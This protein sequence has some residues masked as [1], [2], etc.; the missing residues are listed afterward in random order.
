MNIN[1]IYQ[2]NSFNFDLR[3]DASIKYLEDLASKLI[4]KDKASFNLSYKD[5]ILTGYSNTL[6]KDILKSETNVHITISP[7]MNRAG[8]KIKKDLPKLRI[9]NHSISNTESIETKNNLIM[10]ETELSQSFSENSIKVLQHLSKHNFGNNKKQKNEYEY[11]TKN[12]IFEEVYNSK[13]SELLK[14]LKILSQKIKEYDD[15]LYKKY[16]QSFN[17]NN[18]ELLLFEKNVMNFKDKQI[19]FIKKLIEFFDDFE[20]NFLNDFYNELNMYYNKEYIIKKN[21]NSVNKI[22]KQDNILLSPIYKIEKNISNSNREL[23]LLIKNNNINNKI[24]KLSLSQNI[25]DKKQVIDE[26]S[27]FTKK[28][29]K[30]QLIPNFNIF[31]NI[32]N[33]TDSDNKQDLLY[34][35]LNLKEINNKSD[36]KSKSN[37]KKPSIE[38]TTNANSKQSE[39]SNSSKAQD[40]PVNF[41][42]KN[43]PNI[44]KL[45]NISKSRNNNN[46]NDNNEINNISFIKKNNKNIHTQNNLQKNIQKDIKKKLQTD[47]LNT[48]Q[49]NIQTN[50]QNNLQNDKDNNEHNNLHNDSQT[51]SNN[52]IHNDLLIHLQKQEEKEKGKYHRKKDKK[53]TVQRLKEKEERCRR[54]STVENIE[55]N[56]RKVST[57]FEITESFIKEN[58]KSD[59]SS[60]VHT[61]EDNS[62]SE[63]NKNEKKHV[64]HYFN[65]YEEIK[66]L[67]KKFESK[68]S[69][70]SINYNQIKNP[71]IG[72]LI[73]VKNKK[74]NQRIKRL[75]TNV[76]DF[77]I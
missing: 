23:P 28:N 76:N 73:K 63:H 5:N 6:L 36:N 52:K 31:C 71:K 24:N 69:K 29:S 39:N 17:K 13:E 67:K 40:K 14:F 66:N 8:K 70:R 16:K 9:T 12:K 30:L 53:T 4:N 11:I 25:N 56:K 15:F 35:N 3:K 68:S 72:Y 60:S 20:K 77:L 59:S 18:N 34:N 32:N 22:K 33:N 48:K 64:N 42:K 46:I 21:N 26:K 50:L 44:P 55:Y 1:L 2:N 49:N 62:D 38:N 54:V 58:K 7:K 75:G 43:I 47:T 10:N 37:N 61:S 57:L 45:N 19:K 41:L 27:L 65:D 74:I 51:I